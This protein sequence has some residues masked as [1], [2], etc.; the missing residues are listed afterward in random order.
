ML[1]VELPPVLVLVIPAFREVEALWIATLFVS[2]RAKVGVTKAGMATTTTA[3][4]TI[5]N[6]ASVVIVTTMF[7]VIAKVR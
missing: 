3:A 2:K 1:F 4:A 5:A 6:A 7:L